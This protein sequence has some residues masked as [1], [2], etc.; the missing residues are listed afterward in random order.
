ME[1][2]MYYL[3]IIYLILFVLGKNFSYINNPFDEYR[4]FEIFLALISCIFILV[5]KINF[6]KE[7]LFILSLIIIYFIFSYQYFDP[8]S[9]QDIILWLS[10]YFIYLSLY[11]EQYVESKINIAYSVLVLSSIFSCF[12]VFVSIFNYLNYNSWYDWQLNSGTRRIFDS[13]II[14]IFWLCLYISQGERNR[15]YYYIFYFFIGLALFFSG[16]RSAL[17]SI[18]FPLI[19][20]IFLSK[21]NRLSNIKIGIYLMLSFFVYF[22][23][24]KMHGIIYGIDN[25]LSISR[26]TT[27]KRYEIWEF[28]FK[29]WIDYPIFGVGGGF[30]A[31]EQFLYGHHSHNLFLRL[32]FEWGIL[33]GIFLIFL[34]YKFYFLFKSNVSIIL[35]MGVLSILI[36]AFFSGNFIYPATQ[37]I[38]VLFLAFSFSKIKV[39]HNLNNEYLSKILMVVYISFYLFLIFNFLWVD[40]SC[41]DC[42]SQDGRAA[43]FFWEHGA[44]EHLK[45]NK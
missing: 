1:N 26:F 4:V 9:I 19:I 13:F 30:L 10:I 27:S 31:K 37:V 34:L 42:S 18:F 11:Q 17:L 22:A 15:S 36:D 28:M 38:C 14:P 6:S 7:T 41:I 45:P 5:R 43:P 21:E 40:M 20:L 29:N 16:A 33:G 8:Y 35:K 44:S 25:D 23:V 12:F 24:C 32:I 3:C 39:Q 2:Y